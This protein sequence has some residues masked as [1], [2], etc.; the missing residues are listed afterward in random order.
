[1]KL[2]SRFSLIALLCGIEMA[3]LTGLSM[4]GANYIQKIQRYSF[5]R[6]FAEAYS[7]NGIDTFFT[8]SEC[9]TESLAIQSNKNI[10]ERTV[11]YPE[12]E[13]INAK[14]VVVAALFISFAFSSY[15]CKVLKFTPDFSASSL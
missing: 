10:I 12:F 8:D 14:R 11:P 2:K 13:S 7:Y 6:P 3:F 4:I 9:G 15:C 1:M 5:Q